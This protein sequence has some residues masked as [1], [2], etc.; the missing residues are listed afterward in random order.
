MDL[1]TSTK[2]MAC[3]ARASGRTLKV[4]TNS[5]STYLLFPM[6]EAQVWRISRYGTDGRTSIEFGRV[7]Y[8]TSSQGRDGL[9][10]GSW[11]TTGLRKVEL[12]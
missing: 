3:Q 2:A 12:V 10:I 4:V 8:H 6:E 11:E 5:G 1:F 7:S 9:I